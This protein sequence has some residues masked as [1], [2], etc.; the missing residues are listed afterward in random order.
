MTDQTGKRQHVT[1][2]VVVVADS[3]YNMFRFRAKQGRDL[4]NNR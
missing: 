2:S 3:R 4:Q 1:L